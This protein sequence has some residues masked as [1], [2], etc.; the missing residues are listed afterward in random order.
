MLVPKACPAP[1]CRLAAALLL[2]AFLAFH[3]DAQA[4]TAPLDVQAELRQLREQNSSLQQQ[5]QRQQA[6]IEE[7]SRRVS[8][9]APVAAPLQP[10]GGSGMVASGAGAAPR[11]EP[12]P[13]T[14]AGG[15]SGFS[16]GRVHISGEGA[17]GFFESQHRGQF[18]NSELRV[19]EAKLFVE[20]PVWGEVYFFSELNI[21]TR[22][23]S[24]FSLRPGELY[25][26]VE[27]VSR[28]WGRERQMNLRLGRIDIPFGEEYQ[29]R[30]AIDNPLISH[31]I[32]D[33]W[34]VDEGV[35]L[36]GTVAGVSYALAVQNGGHDVLRDYNSDKSV[37][38]RV[39]G[40]PAPWLHASVSAMRTGA[41]DVRNDKLSELWLGS[42]FVRPL[43]GAQTVTFGANVLE[44]DV[45]LKLHR[46]T[47]KGSGGILTYDD[48][49]PLANNWRRVAYY[50]VEAE[51]PVYGRLYAAA[52]WSQVF[53]GGGFP[54]SGGGNVGLYGFGPAMTTELHR[55]S[56]GLGYRW[57]SHLNAK[58]EYSTERGHARIGRVREFEDF[59]SAV[60]AFGF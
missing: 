40:D 45:R 4:P 2:G 12:S 9:L 29:V 60:V 46:T 52:R 30:D 43:G 6:M 44:G 13:A 57:N 51:Q 47:I 39:G 50:S 17:V 27:D 59:V 55:A 35:E 19:D 10:T 15:E 32:M 25:L 3:A 26:D 14:G 7:L 54:I 33:L 41:L 49:D 53:S 24:S 20:A 8:G 11:P 16:L 37:T 56:I 28:L 34:G 48:N 22:E 36:Y 21:I 58:A 23:E 5:L 42:G 1:S 18:P 38:L 31:S